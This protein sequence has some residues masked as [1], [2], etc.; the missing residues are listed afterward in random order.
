MSGRV[1]M[2]FLLGVAMAAGFAEACV[3]Q[4]QSIVLITGDEAKRPRQPTSDLSFRAGISRGPAINLL[5]PDAAHA[6]VQSPIH[7]QLK[8][9]AHGSAQIDQDSFKLTDVVVPALDLTDRVKSFIKADG[10]D[11]PLAEVPP[12]TY[13]IR[14][15]IKDKDGRSG[16]LTFTLNVTKP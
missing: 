11:V 14:A 1:M 2:T 8:F 13:T 16:S 6:A 7:L 12:G 5:M 15:E 3:S 4:S 10:L 9:A